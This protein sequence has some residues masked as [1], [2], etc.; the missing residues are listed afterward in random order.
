MAFRYDPSN[1][2]IMNVRVGKEYR[3]RTF[4][5]LETV[6]KKFDTEHGMEWQYMETEIR[7]TYDY[8]RDMEKVLGFFGFLAI[9]IASLGLLGMVIFSL[10]TKMQEVGIRK[11]LGA[12]DIRLFV[13]LSK[14]FIL[15]LIGALIL[16]LPPAILL[17][18]EYLN[19]FAFKINIG[20]ALVFV[21]VL[22]V[23]GIGLITIGS[24]VIRAARINPIEII[25]RE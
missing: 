16:F 18:N 13:H 10:E 20:V 23:V 2:S 25:R 7:N 22:I 12:T 21:S 3:E 9:S 11:I 24:Q 8:F 4:A 15:L 6:W 17:G 19:S 1:I 5:E 14:Q